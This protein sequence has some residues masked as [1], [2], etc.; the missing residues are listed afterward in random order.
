MQGLYS[1][2][3]IQQVIVAG[4]TSL[5]HKLQV[6]GGGGLPW[7]LCLQIYKVPVAISSNLNQSRLVSVDPRCSL[8]WNRPFRLNNHTCDAPGN[9]TGQHAREGGHCLVS[10]TKGV[11]VDSLGDAVCHDSDALPFCML[12]LHACQFVELLAQIRTQGVDCLSVFHD[13]EFF[14]KLSMVLDLACGFVRQLIHRSL[15]ILAALNLSPTVWALQT[16]PFGSLGQDPVPRFCRKGFSRHNNNLK[17]TT[18]LLMY[19]MGRF[20]LTVWPIQEQSQLMTWWKWCVEGN[21]SMTIASCLQNIMATL[22][23]AWSCSA[24]CTSQAIQTLRLASQSIV[25][26]VGFIASMPDTEQN[27]NP[28]L[29]VTIWS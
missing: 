5:F 22:P 20:W 2:F 19:V 23:M 8:G 16:S 15:P 24:I 12:P 18:L 1:L 29:W 6:V 17:Y 7:G 28:C 26:Y 25:S 11:N 10:L 9:F 27:S 14:C 3:A 21:I 4:S 13:Y